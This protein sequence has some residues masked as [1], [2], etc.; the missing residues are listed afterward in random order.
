MSN[1]RML[2]LLDLDPDLGTLLGDD[3]RED[4]R[5]QLSVEVYRIPRGP[6]DFGAGEDASPEHVGLLLLDGVVSREVLVADTV[7][8]ELLGPGD[9]VRMWSLHEPTSLL[10]LSVRW[11]CLTESRIAILDRR[12]GS[13]LVH[14]PE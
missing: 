13:R 2:P 12:F 1:R 14:W 10:Q 7:S 9:V 6:W 5:R 8:T 3:R 4:A 11:T